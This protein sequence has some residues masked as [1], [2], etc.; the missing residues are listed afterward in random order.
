MRPTLFQLM[1]NSWKRST[2]FV[3]TA[4]G[5]TWFTYD[6][7]LTQDV[8]RANCQKAVAYGDALLKNPKGRTR[9]ITVILNP[10]AGKRKSKKLYTKWVEPL[11]HLSGIKVS[12]IETESPGQ[13]YD[14]MNIMSDCDGVAVV[15]GDGTVHEVL[16]GLLHRQD[17]AK[18]V[19]DFPIALIPTGQFNSIARY[20]HQGIS[21]RN[22]K[23]LLVQSTMRLV[24]SVTER[25]DVLVV[26]QLV[27]PTDSTTKNKK[28]SQVY[29]L[30]DVRYGKYQDN[31]IKLNGIMFYQTT[32]KP[33]WLK[34]R[35]IFSNSNPKPRIESLS[36][37]Q[38]CI[39]CSKCVA[40]HS[41]TNS[42]IKKEM[43]VGA[44][45]Q[46][47]S[48]MAPVTKA[49]PPSKE[50]LREKELAQRDN[51]DCDKWIQVD[52]VSEISDFRAGMMGDKKVR[53]SLSKNGE[54]LPSQVIEAQDV[55]LKLSLD[56]DEAYNKQSVDSVELDTDSSQVDADKAESKT[57]TSQKEE[58]KQDNL[59]MDG[60]KT[61]VRSLEIST[62][63]RAVTIFTGYPKIVQS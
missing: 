8:M 34:F 13:A 12:L 22:Q 5:A 61:Q 35:S 9:H 10:V 32:I 24:D 28:N 3:L 14:L 56:L 47:W 54:Y 2:F 1:R 36:Y 18:A 11:L 58:E 17:R 52:D 41:L 25:Y 29:V 55:R 51:P 15:G 37:T 31:Y 48:I 16:N 7:S 62:I 26:N 59:L 27:P 46:W 42:T 40:K 21:Y 60:Q 57:T 49:K 30:R 19:K 23:E 50:E 38:P 44:N 63:D 6:Y 43:D 4:S 53:V 39:G 45:R 33:W 20:I